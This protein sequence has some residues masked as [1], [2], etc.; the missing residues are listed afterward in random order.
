MLLKQALT[1]FSKGLTVIIY[2]H[3]HLSTRVPVC[4][5][6]DLS[7]SKVT[8]SSSCLVLDKNVGFLGSLLMCKCYKT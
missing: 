7:K 6:F 2:H 5:Y 1:S 3:K 8:M 4:L